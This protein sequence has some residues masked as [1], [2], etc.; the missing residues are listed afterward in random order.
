MSNLSKGIYLFVCKWK[1]RCYCQLIW[2]K[3]SIIIFAPN[4][5]I[6]IQN[7]LELRIWTK[8]LISGLGN[9]G[10]TTHLLK[11]S[12]PKNK[13]L[14]GLIWGFY[15]GPHF[16]PP[17]VP[18]KQSKPK[19][20]YGYISFDFGTKLMLCGDYGNKNRLTKL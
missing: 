16:Y 4:P 5:G 10:M 7:I 9:S 17:K 6:E 3:W 8:D 14:C 2:Q 13:R 11:P 20:V 19:K 15:H 12:N 1:L 18:K